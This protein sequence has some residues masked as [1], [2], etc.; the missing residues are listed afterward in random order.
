MLTLRNTEGQHQTGAREFVMVCS[1]L[2]AQLLEAAVKQRRA[3]SR[4]RERDEVRAPDTSAGAFHRAFAEIRGLLDLGGRKLTLHSWRRGGAS[5]D[6]RSRGLM[7]VTLLRGRWASV[8]AARL[9]VQDAVAEATTLD[10]AP[11]QRARC[12]QFARRLRSAR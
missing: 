10:L 7:E 2:A 11:A 8:R 12:L 6:F 3:S 1:R 5:A 9:C 4:G